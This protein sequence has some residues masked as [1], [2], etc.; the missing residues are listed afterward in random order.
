M[1]T[2]E[3]K[4][5]LKNNI[6]LSENQ[7]NITLFFYYVFFY[8]LSIRSPFI[9]NFRKYLYCW[10]PSGKPTPFSYLLHPSLLC[11]LLTFPKDKLIPRLPCLLLLF[12]WL[13]LLSF[14][15]AICLTVLIFQS[16]IYENSRG[17]LT[18]SV[19]LLVS[20]RV[21][22]DLS[23]KYCILLG[24]LV[25]WLI[26]WN[27]WFFSSFKND[28]MALIVGYY[29]LGV[30]I[31][32]TYGTTARECADFFGLVIFIIFTIFS[33]LCIS[34]LMI[35]ASLLL[36]KGNFKLKPRNLTSK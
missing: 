6:K 27:S 22:I 2:L 5:R 24:G 29:F 7:Q 18:E 1:L 19:I 28:W 26:W 36:E 33:I 9:L 20:T 8:I 16:L 15:L 11:F 25:G 34:N 30:F 23:V 10:C 31:I 17:G 35:T 32:S 4:S 21:V 12:L 13:K 14:Y 3:I